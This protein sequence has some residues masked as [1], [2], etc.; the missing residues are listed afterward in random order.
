MN[1]IFAIKDIYSSNN[2]G[3]NLL[4]ELMR[5]AFEAV[6]LDASELPEPELESNERYFSSEKHDV[7]DDKAEELVQAFSNALH[8]RK[9]PEDDQHIGE[10]NPGIQVYVHKAVRGV[11]LQVCENDPTWKHK[12]VE[13]TNS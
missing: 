7:P 9:Q 6:G 4:P 13:P 3:G 8:E 10:A 5:S 2:E 11:T 1:F 12:L